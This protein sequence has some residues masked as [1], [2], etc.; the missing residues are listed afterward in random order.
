MLMIAQ[1]TETDGF[2][3][4]KQ[5]RAI[6]IGPL[7]VHRRD[8]THYEITHIATGRAFGKPLCCKAS[9]IALAQAVQ[10]FRWDAL[11]LKRPKAWSGGFT[12]KAV[13]EDMRHVALIVHGWKCPVHESGKAGAA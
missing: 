12:S 13:R 3:G 9:A 11:K 1:G 7:A 4:W 10:G 5:V 8:K 6:R 2:I